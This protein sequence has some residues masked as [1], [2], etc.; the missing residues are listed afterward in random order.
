MRASVRRTRRADGAAWPK[1]VKRPG[2]LHEC[3]SPTCFVENPCFASGPGAEPNGRSMRT[4]SHGSDWH[5]YIEE[6]SDACASER[7]AL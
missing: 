1:Q 5:D 7:F 3:P 2:R 6:R 4:T